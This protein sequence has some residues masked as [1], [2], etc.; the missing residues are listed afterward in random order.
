MDAKAVVRVG[1]IVAGA[2]ALAVVVSQVREKRAVASTA[3][4]DIEAQLSSLDPVRRAAVVGLL[5]RDGAHSL[6]H[7]HEAS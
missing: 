3:V 4:A 5:A 6:H 1:L 2:V 7:G